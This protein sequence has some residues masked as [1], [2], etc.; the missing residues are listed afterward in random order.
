MRARLILPPIHD[1]YLSPERLSAL[2]L[3]SVGRILDSAGWS[4]SLIN[5]P[6]MKPKGCTL[7]LPEELSHLKPHFIAGETGPLSWYRSYR[8]FG[9]SRIESV[10]LILQDSP[11]LVL[12]SCFAWAYAAETLEL[13]KDLKSKAPELVICLG[14]AGSTVN[15]DYFLGRNKADFIFTGEAEPGFYE[16]LK[17]FTSGKSKFSDIPNI[18]KSTGGYTAEQVYTTASDLYPIWSKS[19]ENKKCTKYTTILSRGCP[20]KCRF[21]SNFLTHGRV[22]RKV[23]L[24]RIKRSIKTLPR[25]GALSVN[26]EDDNLLF[27]KEYFLSILTALTNHNKNFRFTAEN[28]LDYSLLDEELFDRLCMLGLS[29]LNI[30][31]A[32]QTGRNA[33]NENRFLDIEQYELV[34]RSAKRVKIPVITYFICGLAGDSPSEIVKTLIYLSGCHTRTGIS[35]FYPVPGLPGFDPDKMADFYPG[36]CRG[37]SAYPWQK[38]LTTAQMM[39]AF[40]LARFSNLLH[41]PDCHPRG[42]ELIESCISSKKLYTL[43]K[44]NRQLHITPVTETDDLMVDEYFQAVSA[45]RLNLLDKQVMTG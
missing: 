30:S 6:L 2:G 7:P 41:T 17:Y 19:G 14:G 33:L 29:S 27:D 26:F 31:L 16:F 34:L 40:R 22:F 3:L 11:D 37:S 44:Y 18:S 4:W 39:T 45:D 43:I 35:L 28:G 1:F 42:R 9:P 12:L 21:C 38:T 23:P 24:E 32:V 13:I 36:L 15:P 8:R 25:N 10:E 20:R 5:L